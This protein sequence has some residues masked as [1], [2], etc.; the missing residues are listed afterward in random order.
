MNR[1]CRGCVLLERKD[2]DS[3]R[4]DWCRMYSAKPETVLQRCLDQG[5]KTGLRDLYRLRGS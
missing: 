1:H 5:S 3:K 4:K 2:A